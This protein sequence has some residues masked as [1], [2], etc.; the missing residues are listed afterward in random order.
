M[1]DVTCPDTYAASHT[2]LATRETGAVAA[3]AVEK[4]TMKFGELARLTMWLHWRSRHLV[5]LGGGCFSRGEEEHEVW[6]AG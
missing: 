3:S 5:H 6:R 1:W 4:K 2:V